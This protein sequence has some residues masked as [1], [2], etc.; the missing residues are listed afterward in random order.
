MPDFQT[1][2]SSIAVKLTQ[3]FS[4]TVVVELEAGRDLLDREARLEE[5]QGDALHEFDAVD[6]VAKERLLEPHAPL[7]QLLVLE[8]ERQ[9]PNENVDGTFENLS[10]SVVANHLLLRREIMH[11][12][13]RLKISRGG[14]TKD[15]MYI[16]LSIFSTLIFR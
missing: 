14:L 4:L 16:K 11:G 7:K 13:N 6:L 5:Q 1:R 9:G 15:I 8:Q 12:L 2:C 3:K 10:L